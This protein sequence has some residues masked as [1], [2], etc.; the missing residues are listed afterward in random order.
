MSVCAVPLLYCLSM[1]DM[2]TKLDTRIDTSQLIVRVCA[3][4]CVQQFGRLIAA[5]IDSFDECQSCCGGTPQ[6]V[7]ELIDHQRP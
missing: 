1:S 7:E 5:M 6:S 2:Q 4:S 3:C